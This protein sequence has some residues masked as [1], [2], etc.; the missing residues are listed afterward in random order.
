MESE[1][2]QEKKQ[3]TV[4]VKEGLGAGIIGLGLL[5]LFMPGTSQ[6]IADIITTTA[7]YSVLSGAVFV[8]GILTVIA[9][10]AVIFTKF[11]DD[12]EE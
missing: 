12:E 11:D 1:Q 2:T 3:I 8:M 9:G 10:L 7:A 5:L 6:K 4:G